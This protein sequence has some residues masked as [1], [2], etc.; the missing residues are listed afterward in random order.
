MRPDLDGDF[1]SRTFLDFTIR[2]GPDGE[3]GWPTAPPSAA[4]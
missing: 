1:P 4:D 2:D 3:P